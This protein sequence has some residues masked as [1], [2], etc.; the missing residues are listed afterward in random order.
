MV[1]QTWPQMSVMGDKDQ[2]I[3]SFTP[4]LL[5]SL[6]HLTD[7]KGTEVTL[8]DNVLNLKKFQNKM[9]VILTDYKRNWGYTNWNCIKIEKNI[10]NL[11][12]LTNVKSFLSFY[13]NKI[14][15][16]NLNYKKK[17]NAMELRLFQAEF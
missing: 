15:N 14:V 17:L 1:T 3:V 4:S 2:G 8:T 9:L 6:L 7:Y 11:K 12:L 10:P 13:R 16:L 5:V